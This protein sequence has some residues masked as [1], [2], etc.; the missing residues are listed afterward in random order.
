[1]LQP[2]RTKYRKAHKGRIHGR[3]GRGEILNYGAYGLKAM[4]PER[5]TSRQIEAARKA[6]TRQLK[7]VGRL[8]IRIFPDV[9]SLGCLYFRVSLACASSS[10]SDGSGQ[11]VCA[12]VIITKT[13]NTIGINSG[14]FLSVIY[15]LM[16]K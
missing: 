9:P 3:A 1:M 13:K 15:F 14:I 16:K 8:W 4:Q 10:S 6:I 2:T 12:Q 11:T 7:R 5:I